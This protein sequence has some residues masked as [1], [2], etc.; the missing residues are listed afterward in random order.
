[1]R[2][3]RAAFTAVTQKRILPGPHFVIGGHLCPAPISPEVHDRLEETAERLCRAVDL[4]DGPANFDVILDR[5]GTIRVLEANLR[6]TGNAVPLLLV[7]VYGVDTV[8]ALVSLATGEPFELT[9]ART[10]TGIV[11]V[12][13]SPLAVDGVLREVRGLDT[14]R[15][16]PGVARCDVY[17]AP[18]SIVR[19]FTEGGHKLGHLIVSGADVDAA[20]STLAAALDELRLVVV[21]AATGSVQH[22]PRQGRQFL[23]GVTHG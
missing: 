16:M 3:G 4:L 5:D 13:G 9:P 11:H 22:A 6:L 23:E 18:G 1:M 2:E 8:A 20:E 17:A 7:H 21:P 15:A 14:V 19:P 10:G 12:L